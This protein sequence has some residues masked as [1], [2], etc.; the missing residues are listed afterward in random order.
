MKLSREGLKVTFVDMDRCLN[1]E[2]FANDGVHFNFQGIK[3]VSKIII[4]VV[5]LASRRVEHSRN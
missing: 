1:I 2:C 4:N 5:N 3:A